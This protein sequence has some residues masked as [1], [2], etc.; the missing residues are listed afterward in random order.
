MSNLNDRSNHSVPSSPV[1]NGAS[2][3]VIV[4][5]GIEE[6]ESTVIPGWNKVRCEKPLEYSDML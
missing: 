2:C 4:V 3:I 5:K 6:F 1:D